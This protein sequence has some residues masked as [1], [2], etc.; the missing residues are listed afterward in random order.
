MAFSSRA[1][2]QLSAGAIGFLAAW[3]ALAQQS[4]P[5]VGQDAPQTSAGQPG[6]GGS[7]GLEEIVV[8]AR[9]RSEK[10]QSVPISVTSFS[11]TQLQ[12][13]NIQDLTQLSALSPSLSSGQA[14]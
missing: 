2:L 4:A 5:V 14:G 3:S 13:R 10:L 11:S 6:S 9:H 12:D 1:L 7:S 8:T